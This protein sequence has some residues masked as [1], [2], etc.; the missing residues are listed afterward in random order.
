MKGRAR[1]SNQGGCQKI[2]WGSEDRPGAHLLLAALIIYWLAPVAQERVRCSIEQVHCWLER[3]D[4]WL[5]CSPCD[6]QWRI[7]LPRQ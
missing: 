7:L 3:F 1:R 2:A 4:P 6:V 5:S